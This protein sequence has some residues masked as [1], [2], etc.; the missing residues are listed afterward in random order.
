MLEERNRKKHGVSWK[1]KMTIYKEK[2]NK[3]GNNNN[4]NN[5]TRDATMK[6]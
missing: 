4:D 6:K 1:R 5:K 2:Y 3:N